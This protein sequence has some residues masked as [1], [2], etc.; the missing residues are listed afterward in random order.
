MSIIDDIGKV[1][2]GAG[3]AV[4]EV[5]SGVGKVWSAFKYV[6]WFLTHVAQ[7]LT[8]AWDWMVNGA[9]YIG[10]GIE[11]L[12]KEASGLLWGLVTHDIPAFGAWIYQHAIRWAWEEVGALAR[13]AAHKI[14]SVIKWAG[15]ELDLL[16]KLIDGWVKKLIHWA[17]GAVQ[18]VERFGATVWHLISHPQLLAELLAAHIVWPVV[19]WFLAQGAHIVVYLLKRAAHQGSDVEHFFEDILHD[20]L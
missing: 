16:R 1:L 15:R 10:V 13:A 8:D 7:L 18:W 9:A 5:V 6:W 14:E 12:T 20:M 3:E 17:Q 11:H 2:G 19:K 4:G